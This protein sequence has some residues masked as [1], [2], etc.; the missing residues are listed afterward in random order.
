MLFWRNK[1]I[2]HS[3]SFKKYTKS[4]SL[5]LAFPL[6]FRCL[7][8]WCSRC[9][10]SLSNIW[11]RSISPF[12]TASFLVSKTGTGFFREQRITR[13]VFRRASRARGIIF[14]ECARVDGRGSYYVHRSIPALAAIRNTICGCIRRTKDYRREF[15][16]AVCTGDLGAAAAII[17]PLPHAE[18]RDFFQR[19]KRSDTRAYCF[20][21]YLARC[22]VRRE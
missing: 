13:A 1:W 22:C 21:R 4:L 6:L 20:R 5:S 16:R 15:Q 2:Y 10:H 7:L 17:L 14:D 9:E 18:E 3:P 8:S 12:S 19:R 11:C